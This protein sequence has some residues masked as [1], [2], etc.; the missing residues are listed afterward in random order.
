LSTYI[1]WFDTNYVV[2]LYLLVSTRD[3]AIGC[4]CNADVG[5]K[6]VYNPG[7]I[8]YKSVTGKPTRRFE[9]M[10]VEIDCVDM[11]SRGTT[12]NLVQ[13]R[14]LLLVVLKLSISFT[15]YLVI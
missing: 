15:T 1:V 10:D 3:V 5:N 6:L 14:P 13:H 11:N 2:N 4:A 8:C 9:M 7:N 12:Q